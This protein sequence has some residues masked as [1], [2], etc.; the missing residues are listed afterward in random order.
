M[1]LLFKTLFFSLLISQSG[2]VGTQFLSIPPSAMDLILFNSPW[3][4]PANLNQMNKVPELGL[5]YGNW[6]AGV[7]SFGFRWKGQVK[8]GSVGLDIR[9][10]GLND[11]ELRPNKPTSKPL[12]HYAAYGTSTRGIYSWSTGPF[13]LGVGIQLVQMQLYQDKSK[14]AA[15]DLGFGWKIRD[16]I[17]LN[18]SAL[19]L[20][21][22]GRMISESPR[23]PR[24]IISSITYEKSNYSVYGAVESNSLV[25]DPIL[26]TGGTGS[27]KNLLFGM[28]AMTSNG[29]KTISGG[30]GIQFGIYAVTYGFQ[31]GDQHLGMPQ[32]IDISIRLP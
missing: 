12:G 9:Y 10:V 32:M 28:T 27:Y 31:W 5:A 21:K 19:N 15:F 25:N 23:L 2:A 24:R 4:N 1:R 16:K 6:L 11:I 20:G 14:G 18:I 7:Q 26:F 13:Q 8:K 22:M 29:V 3:R 30:V 17:R